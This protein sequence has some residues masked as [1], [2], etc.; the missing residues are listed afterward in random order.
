MKLLRSIILIAII[1]LLA[2][3]FITQTPNDDGSAPA[4]ENMLAPLQKMQEMIGES[5]PQ[6]AE[7][8]EQLQT[9]IKQKAA[10]AE[11]ADSIDSSSQKLPI[12]IIGPTNWDGLFKTV[13][14]S[15]E[16]LKQMDA[17]ELAERMNALYSELQTYRQAET[18]RNATN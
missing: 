6:L 2:L 15:S 9:D 11:P 10:N 4:I 5:M 14:I 3:A 18:V 13:E 16:Q 7:K 8:I 12:D 17:T 1:V